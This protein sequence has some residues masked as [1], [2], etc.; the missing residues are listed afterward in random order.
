MLMQP[1]RADHAI[2]FLTGEVHALFLFCQRAAVLHPDRAAMI[3][4]IDEVHLQG[5]A[6][7]GP[8]PVPEAIVE[9][10]EFV[11]EALQ[12]VVAA[13]PAKP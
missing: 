7:I 3:A 9:G 8:T 12:K 11:A 1:E 10:F 6:A 13:F 5:L 4:A 2:K